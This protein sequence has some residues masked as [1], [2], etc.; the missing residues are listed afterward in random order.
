M[1]LK[2][3]TGR[4][5]L[6][7]LS[8]IPTHEIEGEAPGVR[9]AAAGTATGNDTPSEE[10]E[11]T[12]LEPLSKRGCTRTP[13]FSP[14]FCDERLAG[15]PVIGD[16]QIRLYRG[17]QLVIATASW[18]VDAHRRRDGLPHFRAGPQEPGL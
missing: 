1:L 18:G 6:D 13:R 3:A 7:D 8:E 15:Y 9:P 12:Q 5:L 2:T 10:S 16:E 14:I 17:T 4:T 11:M